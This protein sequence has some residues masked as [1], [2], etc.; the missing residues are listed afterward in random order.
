MIV[1]IIVFI[2]ADIVTNVNNSP[3]AKSK[4]HEAIRGKMG[5]KII[6]TSLLLTTTS[7]VQIK[8]DI[9]QAYHGNGLV[10]NDEGFV[11]QGA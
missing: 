5:D 3:W 1:L 11:K 4:V 9:V 7:I 10:V 2:I 8:T 6:S